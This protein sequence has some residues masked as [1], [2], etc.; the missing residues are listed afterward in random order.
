[1]ANHIPHWVAEK[2]SWPVTDVAQKIDL[3]GTKDGALHV[4]LA[5]VHCDLIGTQ[6]TFRYAAL[7]APQ[8]VLGMGLN[9][10]LNVPVGSALTRS[11]CLDEQVSEFRL[12]CRM[13]VD[14][15]LF[16]DDC[17]I[18]LGIETLDND[19]QYLRDAESHIGK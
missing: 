16:H 4:T 8:K 1:V 6:K 12:H 19:G 7:K 3:Q 10:K 9:H 18:R 2:V 17:R 14:L 5:R 15:W 13:E 11:H